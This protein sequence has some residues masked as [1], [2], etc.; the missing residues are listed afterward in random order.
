M[1][2]I[3]CHVNIAPIE[4]R[5]PVPFEPNPEHPWSDGVHVAQTLVIVSRGGRINIQVENT[6]PHGV[7]LRKRTLLGQLHLVRSA[8]PVEVTKSH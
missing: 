1:V 7:T 8:T 3:A 2:H 4:S 5:V 6:T